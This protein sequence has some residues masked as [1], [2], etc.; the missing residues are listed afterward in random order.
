MKQQTRTEAACMSRGVI[1]LTSPISM[2][3]Y[4]R[5]RAIT[6]FAGNL[7]SLIGAFP[8]VFWEHPRIVES[9]LDYP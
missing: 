4:F 7:S 8:L 5:G 1:M 2:G 9:D 3:K 6:G